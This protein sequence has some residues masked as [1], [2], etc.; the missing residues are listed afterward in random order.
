MWM[1]NFHITNRLLEMMENYDYFMSLH[2]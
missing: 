1:P 2:K